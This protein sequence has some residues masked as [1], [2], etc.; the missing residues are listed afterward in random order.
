MKKKN[1][2]AEEQ[3][4][5]GIEQL[6]LGWYFARMP[7]NRKKKLYA[8]KII[9]VIEESYSNLSAG[10][11]EE[12]DFINRRYKKYRDKLAESPFR[13]KIDF[14]KKIFQNFSKNEKMTG[15]M[16]KV[17]L[18]KYAVEY[19]DYIINNYVRIQNQAGLLEF[20]LFLIVYFHLAS[21]LGLTVEI[22]YDNILDSSKKR[23][24]K[25]LPAGISC[26]SPYLNV[27]ALDVQTGTFKHFVLS[28]VT[29]I[30]TDIF[31]YYKYPDRKRILLDMENFKNSEDY[32]YEMKHTVFQ[33]R[34]ERKFFNHFRHVYFPEFEI[35]EEDEKKLILNI[36][37]WD[38]R[39]FYNAIFNYRNHCT[40]L[41]P[42][43][44]AVFYAEILKKT[45][46]NYEKDSR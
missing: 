23:K 40:L 45:L 28:C 29:E 15:L 37:T 9:S 24:R 4:T 8:D 26:R 2:T 41:S 5:R 16:S 21:R 17:Y 32:R 20:S 10:N 22:T 44:N 39:Y 1:L 38:H 18:E 3:I 36:C 34:L 13:I 6:A 25:I 33:I 35:V 19:N 12:T 30:H 14:Q 43:E 31:D 27:I 46:K 11:E 42:E 7:K